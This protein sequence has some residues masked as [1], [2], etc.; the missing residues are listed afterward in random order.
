M[1]NAM[2]MKTSNQMNVQ[3]VQKPAL[4]AAG[5]LQRK[6]ACG[7]HTIGGTECQE[8]GKKRL[9]RSAMDQSTPAEIPSLV[10]ET[11]RQPGQ[12]LERETRAFMETRLG[13]DFSNVRVHTDARAAESA[14]AVNALAYTVGRQV[15][16]G[17]GR[18]APGTTAGRQLLAHELTHVVQQRSMAADGLPQ[19]ISDAHGPM[20]QEADKLA[21]QVTA[22]HTAQPQSFGQNTLARVVKVENPDKLIPNPTGK[23]LKQTNAATVSEY[24]AQL[25]S[26][27]AP[28]IDQKSGVAS[29]SGAFCSVPGF[30]IGHEFLPAGPMPAEEAKTATGCT[31][32]CDLI[33]GKNE[34]II[35]VD[36]GKRPNTSFSD[37]DAA[38]GKKPG[39]S[40]GVVTT[41]SPN[42]RK[43]FGSVS[44]SGKKIDYD[45]WLILGH[46][47]CGHGWLGNQG[48]AESE[49]IMETVGRQPLTVD[50]ENALRA[51]HEI[52]AR[53]RSFRDPFC[54]ESYERKKS[55]KKGTGRF[56]PSLLKFCKQLRARCRKPNKKRFKIEERIPEDATCK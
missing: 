53:G 56:E 20:E 21:H 12:A 5:V 32:L 37:D 50:R 43:V 3:E 48:T 55:G 44:V 6:C 45:P 42:S 38:R 33:N 19:K 28:K 36:D 46:E 25:C 35:K 41:I 29:L 30:N 31:C 51:E 34:W 10:H 54:G 27:E 39:G 23:G 7:Q 24:F 11:L 9:Q 4:A 1:Q 40:G 49:E 22:G 47:L 8:C 17:A 26:G 16:F 2:G 18:Y 14:E 15:V 13:H 52:E